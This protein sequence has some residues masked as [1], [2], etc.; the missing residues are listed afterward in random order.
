[1]MTHLKTIMALALAAC[2]AACGGSSLGEL[3]QPRSSGFA[4][5]PT[6]ASAPG[7][8][9]EPAR[10]AA[11]EML[12]LSTPGN[13]GYKV[14]PLDVL[15]ITVFK[16]PDLSKTLQVSEAGTINYPL[17]GEV[18]AAGRTA[19]E[20]EQNLTRTLG[21]RYL[22]N[23]QVTVFVKEYNSQRVTVEGAVK[24][25]GVYPIQGGMSLLQAVAIAQ[26]LEQTSDDTVIVFREVN[27]QRAAARFDVSA[28]RTGGMRDPQLQSGDVVVAGTSA[29]KEG[30]NTLIKLAPIASVFALL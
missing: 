19:R 4:A 9:P 1:M 15:D 25:P 29:F 2:L 22:Q 8:D 3:T 6:A 10:R 13:K 28:I 5:T 16:V 23:P 14:G 11:A 21:S 27:G 7:V 26:G 12:A 24:K 18:Q 20:I 17:V 30:F